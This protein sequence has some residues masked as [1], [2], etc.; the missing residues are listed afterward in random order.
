[1]TDKEKAINT[2]MCFKSG[3]ISGTLSLP[4]NAATRGQEIEIQVST[5]NRVE[6]LGV[7]APVEGQGTSF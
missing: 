3:F 6:C 5:V 2:F 1:M 7:H 4:N